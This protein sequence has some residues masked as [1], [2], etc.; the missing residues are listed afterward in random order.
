MPLPEGHRFPIEKYALLRRR[1][2]ESGLIPPEQMQVP[3]AATADQLAL[4]HDPEYIRRVLH[5]ELTPQELRRIGFPWSPELA[6]RACRSV[7]ATIA[8][9]RAALA[10]GIAVSLSG[11]THH[12]GRAHGAGYCVFND[13]AVAARVM[14]AE[15]RARRVVVI[16]CDV[17]Q[18]DGTAAIFAGDPTV[19]TFSIHGAKNFPFRKE[20]SDLDVALPDGAGDSEYLAALAPALDHALAAARADLAIYLAGSDPYHDDKLGR[21][22]LTK[23]GLAERD[24][25]VLARCRA[26]GLPTAVTMAGG[27][28]R[29]VRDTAEI[30]FQTVRLAAA[31]AAIR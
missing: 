6:E 2:A 14:Q 29:D 23:A 27:Y 24:R 16:D 28:A 20:Q 15:G 22:A 5:G 19:F 11:G 26:A 21:M 18:G 3:A 25:L 10:D 8:A 30:H 9:C 31:A 12:A 13:V 17:H 7:G 4:A 1:V